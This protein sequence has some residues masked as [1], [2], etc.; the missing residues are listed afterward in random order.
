MWTSKRGC[1]TSTLELASLCCCSAKHQ[2]VLL[3][4]TLSR[5]GLAPPPRPLSFEAAPPSSISSSI[6]N[7]QQ[8]H[9]NHRSVTKSPS[10]S[11]EYTLVEEALVHSRLLTESHTADPACAVRHKRPKQA[12]RS[13]R[14]DQTSR[15]RVWTSY[16]TAPSRAGD[17]RE[18]G[19]LF[20]AVGALRTRTIAGR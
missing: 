9:L 7:Q 1:E 12:S 17:S 13:P 15:V 8:Q 11:D 14:P 6:I 20:V 18:L 5:F 3:W 19:W 4:L 10:D 16:I 2:K